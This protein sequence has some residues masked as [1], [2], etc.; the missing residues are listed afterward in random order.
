MLP[1]V[2]EMPGLAA[3]HGKQLAVRMTGLRRPAEVEFSLLNNIRISLLNVIADIQARQAADA[4]PSTSSVHTSAAVFKVT[5][6]IP[7]T[8]S[9]TAIRNKV[10][11]QFQDSED[12]PQVAT[13][14]SK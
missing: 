7:S 11:G 4:L 9:A 2:P 8:S 10:D 13:T 3:G 14:S 12:D 5:D 6:S 1:R